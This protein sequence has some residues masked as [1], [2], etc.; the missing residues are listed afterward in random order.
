MRRI[1]AK[2]LWDCIRG[3]IVLTLVLGG[4]GSSPIYADFTD[5]LPGFPVAT[6]TPKA[7]KAPVGT[8]SPS[9]GAQPQPPSDSQ[10]AVDTSR[11][12]SAT[13]QP[14][15]QAKPQVREKPGAAVAPG[16]TTT[17]PQEPGSGGLF[18]SDVTKHDTNALVI[19]KNGDSLEGSLKSGKMTLRGNV[20]LQQADTTLKADSCELYSKPGTTL[21]E[22]AVARGKVS[23]RKR[24]LAGALELRASADEV[25]YFIPTRRVILKGRPKV[26]RGDELLQGEVIEVNLDT[27]DIV[28]RGASAVVDPKLD[29]KGSNPEEAGTDGGSTGLT[30]KKKKKK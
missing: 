3:S 16:T 20:E 28:V 17:P 6:P 2:H 10:P 29:S 1:K 13:P 21:P 5:V 8:G 22:R 12:P 25:E 18:A 30:G 4:T 24:P 11:G 15:G 7:P 27:E 23:V 14:I 9:G 26:W 19:L